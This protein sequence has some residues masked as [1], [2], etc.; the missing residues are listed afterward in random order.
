M[1]HFED[2]DESQKPITMT[3]YLMID[4]DENPRKWNVAEWLDDPNVVGWDIQDGHPDG[5]PGCA[6]NKGDV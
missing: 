3:V 6:P 5:C 2:S 4:E 1:S